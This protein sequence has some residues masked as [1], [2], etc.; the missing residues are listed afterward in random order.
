MLKRSKC[1]RSRETFVSFCFNRHVNIHWDMWIHLQ[2]IVANLLIYLKIIL[3]EPLKMLWKKEEDF[4][5]LLK[6]GDHSGAEIWGKYSILTEDVLI[7]VSLWHQ[8][9][10]L[11]IFKDHQ[12]I[13]CCNEQFQ[14]CT[15][16]LRLSVS[17]RTMKIK[18]HSD[19]DEL[20]RYKIS[21]G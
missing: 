13:Q 14:H 11:I 1:Y 17:Q 3:Y 12:W 10:F 18:G 5:W 16:A 9:S 19:C 6:I 8:K 7:M 20:A 4:F 21:K 2:I 15:E